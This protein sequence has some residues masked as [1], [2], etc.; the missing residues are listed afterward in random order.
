[1]SRSAI[2][3]GLL[4]FAGS[5]V[6]GDE[7]AVLTNQGLNLLAGSTFN[8]SYPPPLNGCF[9]GFLPASSGNAPGQYEL[10]VFRDGKL[11]TKLPALE[12]ESDLSSDSKRH[13]RVLAVAF[14]DIDKDG[15]RDVLLIGQRLIASGNRIF[16][17][18]YW[19]CGDRFVYDEDAGHTVDWELTGKRDINVQTVGK[20]LRYKQFRSS[21]VP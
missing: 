13:L 16:A 2:V 15:R 9:T 12:P 18:I 1:M 8:L 19:G 21:C 6:A 14:N 10:G 5:A 17:Q 4:L 3:V 20:L 11:M 7:C